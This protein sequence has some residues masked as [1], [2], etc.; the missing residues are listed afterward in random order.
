MN[1]G[2]YEA[3]P[4]GNLAMEA[5]SGSTTVFIV[6]DDPAVR[7]AIR[8]LVESVGLDCRLFASGPEFLDACG[9]SPSGCLVVDVRMAGI[10]GLELQE[11]LRER[12]VD[13]PIIVITGHGDVPMAV[14]AMKHGAVDFLEKPFR[15][16]AL[17][18]SINHA[19]AQNAERCCQ[20]SLR[21][22]REA[23]YALLSFRERE[24]FDLLVEGQA[25]K[26]IAFRLS[27]SHRT[28]EVHRAHIMDK[29]G[30]QSVSDLVRF[31]YSLRGQPR[32]GGQV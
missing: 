13:I 23:R 12:G 7:D 19:L 14:Q 32:A 15:N 24:V 8:C 27:L 1:T 25:T 31:A 3:R 21:A 17:L 30:A 6:D 26:R 5:A 9:T 10:S 28:V 20:K 16:Q 18:N 29:I 2:A 4:A 22:E 11:K